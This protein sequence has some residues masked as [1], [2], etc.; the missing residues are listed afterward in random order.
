MKLQNPRGAHDDIVTAVA[1]V[2]PDLTNTPEM[3]TTTFHIPTG[4]LPAH[5]RHQSVVP[6]RS[7]VIPGS[8]TAAAPLRAAARKS[9]RP[10]SG[11][12]LGVPGAWDD[13]QRNGAHHE[14]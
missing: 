2:H 5:A 8:S 10:P 6:G 11:A 9:P 3:S 14:V 13:P 7:R 1:M 4:S 12:I